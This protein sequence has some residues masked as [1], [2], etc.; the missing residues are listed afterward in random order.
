MQRL[1]SA[2]RLHGPARILPRLPQSRIL[3]VGLG[4]GTLGAG[5]VGLTWYRLQKE[6]WSE[7][8]VSNPPMPEYLD[9]DYRQGCHALE[10]GLTESAAD[11]LMLAWQNA[12]ARNEDPAVLGA[13]AVGVQLTD[14]DHPQYF[15]VISTALDKL[16][17]SRYWLEGSVRE[18][19]RAMGFAIILGAWLSDAEEEDAIARP[20]LHWGT[21]QFTELADEGSLD[22]LDLPMLRLA[23]NAYFAEL[24]EVAPHFLGTAAHFDPLLSVPGRPPIPD[25]DPALEPGIRATIAEL[26]LV[27][28]SVFLDNRETAP[29]WWP[30]VQRLHRH[31]ARLLKG[32]FNQQF[33]PD[34]IALYRSA[35]ARMMLHVGFQSL[36]VED[37][38]GALEW[39]TTAKQNVTEDDPLWEV[40]DSALTTLRLLVQQ[41]VDAAETENAA[42]QR[43]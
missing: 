22:V 33:N 39:L 14:S 31:S 38:R 28:A 35:M 43:R 18:R 13:I 4:V 20:F 23:A 1:V 2:L 6:V 25:G 15:T 19:R 16:L 8:F 21:A 40:I 10:Y 9:A 32:G 7:E 17:H 42:K 12:L 24:V 29:S 3:R 37:I 26:Y 27:L 41:A 30:I 5:A 36:E 11:F 34:E